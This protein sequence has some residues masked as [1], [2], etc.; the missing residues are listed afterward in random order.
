MKLDTTTGQRVRV[1]PYGTVFNFP[2]GK[3]EADIIIEYNPDIYKNPLPKWFN[4]YFE[5]RD[6][7]QVGPHLFN[8]YFEV[9]A[10]SCVQSRVCS[11]S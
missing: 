1:Y 4:R 10:G 6:C 7:S 3:R 8:S 9:S 5:V 11:L 2:I